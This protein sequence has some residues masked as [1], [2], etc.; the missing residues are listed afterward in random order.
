MKLRRGRTKIKDCTF[1]QD[2]R[3]QVFR[4]MNR[5]FAI[6]G[7]QLPTIDI[8]TTTWC[9]TLLQSVADRLPSTGSLISKQS[10]IQRWMRLSQEP[11]IKSTAEIPD[12]CSLLNRKTLAESPDVVFRFYPPDNEVKA[13]RPS[14]PMLSIIDE[15]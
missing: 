5:C 11:G 4:D 13:Y 6:G 12:V 7:P 14:V 9:C 8:E 1:L 10:E 2:F 15:I 3:L